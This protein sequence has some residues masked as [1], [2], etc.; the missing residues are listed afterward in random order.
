MTEDISAFRKVMTF[1][2]VG[3]MLVLFDKIACF[4]I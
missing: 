3:N 4:A 2:Q 1:G